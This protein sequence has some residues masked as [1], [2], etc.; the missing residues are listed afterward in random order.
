MAN[1][2]IQF[3]AFLT[4]VFLTSFVANAATRE[5]ITNWGQWQYTTT[6]E[7]GIAPVDGDDIT[8]D[9]NNL[10]TVVDG[11]INLTLTGMAFT[12]ATSITLYSGAIL[13]V[14]GDITNSANLTIYVQGG[15]TLIVNGEIDSGS[16]NVIITVDNGGTLV[17]TGGVTSGGNSSRIT[18]GGDI[19]FDGVVAVAN[20]LDFDVYNTGTLEVGGLSTGNGATVT[21]DG[22]VKVNG[23]V[24]LGNNTQ[25]DVYNGSSFTTTGDFTAGGGSTRYNV[26]GAFVVGGNLDLSGEPMDIDGGS[27]SVVVGGTCESLDGTPGDSDRIECSVTREVALPVTLI[28]F[29][30]REMGNMVVL[31]WSTATEV[32]NDYFTIKRSFDGLEFTNLT[33]VQGSGTTNTISYYQYE[34]YIGGSSKNKPVYYELSQTDYDG[35]YE[36]LKVIVLG[37][38][39]L[40]QM[41]LLPNMVDTNGSINVSGATAEL[42][43]KIISLSG[44]ALKSGDFIDSSKISVDGLNNGHYFLQVESASGES[45]SM[46]FVVK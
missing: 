38:G 27:G 9:V 32:D 41:S 14:N 13:T 33:F 19:T 43:W 45:R 11:S 6:W 17:S 20:N 3:S 42:S 26:D 30:G 31:D 7:G 1:R 16:G 23:D 8:S 24:N 40:S 12:K 22:D 4:F 25:M 39:E 2:L 5:I 35:S 21:V 44:T 29:E 15:A 37:K 10:N 18:A 46:R 36:K 34:D 28:N